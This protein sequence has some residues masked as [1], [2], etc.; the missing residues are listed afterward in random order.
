MLD[1]RERMTERFTAWAGSQLAKRVPHADSNRFLEGAFAPIDHETTEFDLRVTGELPEQLN[2][3]LTRIGPN[4]INVPNPAAYHWFLGD[5]MV[6]GVRLRDGKA[7]WYRSRYVGTDTAHKALGRPKIGGSRRGTAD[8]VNTNAI[9]HAG[10]YFALVEGGS[11]PIELDSNLESVRQG[12]FDSTLSL[13]FTAHPHLDPA[14]GKL[15]AI[16]YDAALNRV[17]YVV[18]DANCNV[19]RVVDLTMLT[20]GPMI[21][22]CAITSTGV[23]IFDLPVTLSRKAFIEGSRFPYRWN[24]Q[25]AARVGFLPFDGTAADV[26]W[27]SVDPCYVFHTCNAF[28]LPGGGAVVDVVVHDTIFANEPNGPD[29]KTMTFERWTL[30]P[31]SA[32]VRRTVRNDVPQEFP[33]FDERMTGKPYRYG[34]TVGVTEAKLIRYDVETG[35]SDVHDYGKD[36]LT[37]EAVF[38][39]RA[40]DAA[41]GDGWV[42]SYVYDMAS[43]TTDV[44]ILNASDLGGE[45]AAV[46]HLPVRVPVG[47]HGNWVPDAVAASAS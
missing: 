15:H 29:S 34:I 16:C 27:F 5:G 43:D 6:H 39:P 20:D 30:D 36:K 32:S 4:P 24:A 44:V 33:R 11:M 26:R 12:L 17:Q 22:D 9:G 28:D 45:P 31:Q 1:L 13:P 7:V 23:L 21:H 3:V 42:M 2:G 41:E 46:V 14:T 18:I 47:F 19:E 25:R 10:R 8:V 40:D 38:V 37:S 35:A